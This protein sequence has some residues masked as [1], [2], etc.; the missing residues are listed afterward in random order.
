M[1]F[2]LV[3]YLRDLIAFVDALN[4]K[5]GIDSSS[6]IGTPVDTDQTAEFKRLCG[7]LQTKL[8]GITSV[9]TTTEEEPG[10]NTEEPGTNTEDPTEPVAPTYVATEDETPQAGTTYYT[11]SGEEGSYEYTEFTGE[12][13]ENG[14]TY[15][16]VAN[17][18]S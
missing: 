13:F 8:A 14:V 4:A 5:Y 6:D 3:C 11:R 7:I 9:V 16:V 10:T 17:G 2:L 1:Y 18:E 12:T 15:Y